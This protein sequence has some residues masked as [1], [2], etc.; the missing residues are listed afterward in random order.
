MELYAAR[1]TWL[2]DCGGLALDLDEAE[3][4]GVKGESVAE[5][6]A[7]VSVCAVGR[8]V[9]LAFRRVGDGQGLAEGG[10]RRHGGER[11]WGGGLEGFPGVVRGG[12]WSGLIPEMSVLGTKEWGGGRLGPTRLWE[13]GRC[14]SSRMAM[15]QDY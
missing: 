14:T 15:L 3:G 10:F 7:E 11:K 5:E 2:L 12:F 1:V 4:D 9:E 8:D 13:P 6:E